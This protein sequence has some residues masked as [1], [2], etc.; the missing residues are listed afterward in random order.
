VVVISSSF[1]LFPP[2]AADTLSF[3]N[4]VNSVIQLNNS[5]AGMIRDVVII[6]TGAIASIMGFYFGNRGAINAAKSATESSSKRDNSDDDSKDEGKG[7]SGQKTPSDINKQKDR[8]SL[9]KDINKTNPSPEMEKL[10]P[11][12]GTNSINTTIP[13]DSPQIPSYSDEHRQL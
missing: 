8:N 11:S 3:W 4:T 13:T 12:S 5:L 2:S 6:L 9:E 1:A 10:S 7:T